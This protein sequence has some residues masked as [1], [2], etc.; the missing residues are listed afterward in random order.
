MYVAGNAW[1]NQEQ[2]NQA[3]NKSGSFFSTKKLFHKNTYLG[4]YHNSLRQNNS[5]SPV[6]LCALFYLS[7]DFLKKMLLWIIL[8]VGL[9]VVCGECGA[10]GCLLQGK[11]G[12]YCGGRDR[13]LRLDRG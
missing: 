13:S 7:R 2:K 6:Y 12:A 10:L 3:Q 9:T 1:H 8:R 11:V 5:K 4:C